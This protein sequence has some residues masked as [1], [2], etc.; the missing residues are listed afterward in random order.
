MPPAY[1]KWGG[2]AVRSVHHGYYSTE[3]RCRVWTPSRRVEDIAQFYE[4]REQE[5]GAEAGVRGHVAVAGVALKGTE[6]DVNIPVLNLIEHQLP[7]L[8]VHSVPALA[9]VDGA[10]R[11]A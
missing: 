1:A 5:L 11:N 8:D 9:V 10:H 4:V 3:A 7:Q 6:R 2:Q